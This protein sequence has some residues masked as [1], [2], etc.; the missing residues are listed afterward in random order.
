MDVKAFRTF[1][2]CPP[3]LLKKQVCPSRIPAKYFVSTYNSFFSSKGRDGINNAVWLTKRLDIRVCPYCNRAYIF[4][5]KGRGTIS[6]SVRPELDHF[7]PKSN[8]KYKHLA[9]SFYN[10]IPAC[11]SCNHLKSTQIFDFHPY[12]GG[13]NQTLTPPKIVVDLKAKNGI[14]VN[15]LFPEKPVVRIEP[16]NHNTQGLCLEELY[17]HHSD[18][19]KELLDKIQAYNGSLYQPLIESFQSIGH[20]AE[21]INRLIWGNYIEEGNQTLRPLSKMTHDILEQFGIIVSLR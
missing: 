19:A 8:P 1:I 13:L 20:T 17:K 2:L 11:P 15:G 5:L 16:S 7:Y 9:I 6:R 21:E 14:G 4:T 18:Y 10:L 3:H 12:A